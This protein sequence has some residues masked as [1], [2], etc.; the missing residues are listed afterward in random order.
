MTSAYSTL[1]AQRP[2]KRVKL[3]FFLIHDL[4]CSVFFPSFIRADWLS[5][6][7]KIRL[8]EWKAR[9]DLAQYIAR[10]S[11]A[12]DYSEIT[13]YTPL[14]LREGGA[15]ADGWTDVFQRICNHPDDGH[16]SK[17]IRALAHGEQ[18]CGNVQ[19]KDWKVQKGDWITMG[20][21]AV[22]SVQG[23]DSDWVRSTGFD[24]AWDKVMDRKEF[25]AQ[26]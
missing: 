3:D 15:G 18:A 11:P 21:M 6:E 26:L 22:D 10:G 14:S 20:H 8:L 7:D 2:T 25:V 5:A 4:N 12:L 24:K 17:V 16:A 13:S 9:G 1:A 19:G 23:D